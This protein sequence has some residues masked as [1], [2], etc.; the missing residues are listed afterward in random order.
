MQRVKD[1]NRLL[2]NSDN[3]PLS[4]A[5]NSAYWADYPDLLLGEKF[6][7]VRNGVLKTVPMDKSKHQYQKQGGYIII[8][9]KDGFEII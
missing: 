3:S 6:A 1:I 8:V 9:D 2:G 4:K 7:V 5:D